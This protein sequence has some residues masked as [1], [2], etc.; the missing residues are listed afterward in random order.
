MGI[1]T[2]DQGYGNALR[3]DQQR[4][5]M[6]AAD[7]QRN[8]LMSAGR[9]YSAGD[10]PAAS[11]ALAMGGMLPQAIQLDQQ[12]RTNQ[13]ADVERQKATVLAAAKGLMELPD[14]RWA[15]AL[16]NNVAPALREVGLGSQYDQAMADGKITREEVRALVVAA[17]GEVPTPYANDRAGPDG[18]VIRPDATG[19]YQPVYTAPVDPLDTQYREAQI[20]AMNASAGQRE[21]AAARS[22][23][24]A[25]G[26]GG[27][28]R[29]SGG[30]SRSSGTAP[31]GKPWERSW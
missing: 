1:E 29:S 25:V 30:S 26:R 17:G 23:R 21:A 9:A 5:E 4:A 3:R 19:A 15:D 6:R 7:E 10:R 8:A 13:Q 18:S 28:S 31:A 20:A 24:P 27:G 14:D 16:A 12:T 2:Y 22:R 11:T